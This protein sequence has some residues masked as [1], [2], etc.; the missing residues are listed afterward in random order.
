M[1]L[2]E[3]TTDRLILRMMKDS[4]SPAVFKYSSLPEVSQFVTW[5]PHKALEDSENYVKFV[6]G[7]YEKGV[8]TFAITLKRNPDIVIG[9][10]AAFFI[11]PKDKVM[12]LGAVLSPEHWGKGIMPEA[13]LKLIEYCW[14]TQ[15][16]IRIQ[17]RCFKENKRSYRMLEKLGMR[18]E[19]TIYSSL[20]AK[21]K[22]WDMEMFSLIKE[23]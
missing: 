23:K 18:Y 13:L 19:G 3:L 4:D 14:Q 20:F 1:L 8:I 15:D 21:D 10:M 17:S 2:P 9:D 16:V 6:Q 22:A 11:S 12:E 5:E 7:N